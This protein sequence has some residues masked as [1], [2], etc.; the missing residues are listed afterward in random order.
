VTDTLDATVRDEAQITL[1]A[2]DAKQL[3]A[4]LSEFAKLMLS[5]TVENVQFTG[6]GEAKIEAPD[7]QTQHATVKLDDFSKAELNVTDTLDATVRG[8]AKVNY[9]G[10]PKITQNISGEGK[11]R[12]VKAS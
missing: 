9:T 2:Q 5:G 11:V 3:T 7:L 10:G 8:Q 1:G 4:E 12:P 6:T